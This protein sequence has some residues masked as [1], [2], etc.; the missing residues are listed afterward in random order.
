MACFCLHIRRGF[1]R[2]SVLMGEH[3]FWLWK[4]R[5]AYRY[6]TAVRPITV[7][8]SRFRLRSRRVSYTYFRIVIKSPCPLSGVQA[9]SRAEGALA[10]FALRTIQL[11][12]IVGPHPV[13]LCS[14]IVEVAR[15]GL[16]NDDLRDFAV[17]AGAE[18]PSSQRHGDDRD[19]DEDGVQGHAERGTVRHGFNG[20]TLGSGL[21]GGRNIRGVRGDRSR[22]RSLNRCGTCGRAR[23]RTSRGPW[24][25]RRAGC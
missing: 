20:G 16:G 2:N 3:H 24:A 22:S 5:I 12:S 13:T 4:L 11:A 8:P 21:A 10:D 18:P 14:C 15:L 9:R 19:D 25:A 17:Y 1:R 23:C 6:G 7:R